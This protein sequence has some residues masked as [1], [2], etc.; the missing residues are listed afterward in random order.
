MIL[1]LVDAH[2]KFIDAHVVN[3]ATT[4]TTVT[5][6][7]QSSP[8]HPASNGLAERAVHTLKAALWN[9]SGN[10][11]DRLYRFLLAYRVTPQATTAE[12][13]AD[14]ILKRRPRTRLDLLRPSV[15]N[16][17]LDKQSY[18][19]QRHNANASYR[20]FFVGDCVWARNFL[21]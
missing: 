7:R 14:L 13:P 18:D 2:S 3:A 1:V 12:A 10:L 19:Q 6:L 9:S 21:G 11:E 16:R 15:Q 5:K 4:A 20:T 17:V 8:Y